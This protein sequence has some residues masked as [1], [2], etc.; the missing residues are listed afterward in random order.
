MFEDTS[1]EN[2]DVKTCFKLLE[3]VYIIVLYFRLDLNIAVIAWLF[4][5]L[6]PV[7]LQDSQ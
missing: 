4:R 7:K 2:N 1:A 3:L 5:H 6:V